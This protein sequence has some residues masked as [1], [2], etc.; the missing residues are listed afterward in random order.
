MQVLKARIET[1][2]M[3]NNPKKYRELEADGKLG[4][5]LQMAADQASE[6]MNSTSDDANLSQRAELAAE[7]LNPPVDFL[8][9]FAICG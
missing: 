4:Q 8:A 1:N 3:R 9:D 7:H 2:L 6:A 5:W